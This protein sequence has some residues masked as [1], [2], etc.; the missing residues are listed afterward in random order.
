MI[1]DQKIT[2]LNSADVLR[3]KGYSFYIFTQPPQLPQYSD[4]MIDDYLPG[5]SSTFDWLKGK[6]LYKHQYEALCS[7]EEGKNVVLIAGTGSGK[8]E[9][10]VFYALKKAVSNK[11]VALATYPTLAL[12]NDQVNR[13]EKYAGKLGVSVIKI[14]K[15]T[16]DEVKAIKGGAG[17]RQAIASS[18][19]VLTNPAF[20]L[21]DIKRFVDKQSG[22]YLYTVLR[23]LD[24]LVIDELDFYTPRS[25]ALLLGMMKLLYTHLKV[26]RQVVVMTATLSNP[27]EMCSFLESL[28]GRECVIIRGNPFNVENRTLVVLGKNLRSIWEKIQDVKKTIL[29]TGNLDKDVLKALD[30]YSVFERNAYRVINYLRSLGVDVPSPALSIPELLEPYVNDHGVTIVFT[31]SINRA[32]E[33]Y[34]EL[35]ERNPGLMDK[36]AVHHHLVDRKK[37]EEI[38]MKARE[39]RIRIIISPRTLSQGIDIGTVIRIVHVGLPEELREFRQR[40]GRKGRRENIVFTESIVI[41]Q[42]VFDINLLSK[43]ESAFKKWLELPIEK[44]IVNSDNKYLYLFTGIA[45]LKST[46]MDKNLDEKEIFVL[47]KTRVLEPDGKVDYKRLDKV[48]FNLNF[49]EYSPPYGIPRSL[50]RED[51]EIPLEPI[52]RCDLVEKFQVGCFDLGSG[53]VVLKLDYGRGRNVS[54]VVE[55]ELSYR[56]LSMLDAFKDAVEQYRDIKLRWGESPE[57]IR[58][59]FRAKVISVV[60]TVVYPPKMGFGELIKIPNRVNWVVKSDKPR[61]VKLADNHHVVFDQRRISLPVSTHGEYRDFTSGIMIEAMENEDPILIRLGLAYILIVLRRVYSYSISALEYS[62]DAVG[63]KVFFE[64]HEPESSGLLEKIDWLDIRKSVEKY[65]PDELDLLLLSLIDDVAWTDMLTLGL[66]WD[67][68]K[69]GALRVIDY[70]LLMDK[71]QAFFKGKQIVIPKPSKALKLLSIEIVHLVDDSGSI[72]VNKLFISMFDGEEAKTLYAYYPAIRGVTPPDSLR[73]LEMELFDKVLYEGYTLIL[74]SIISMHSI[75]DK[76]DLRGLKHLL[77]DQKVNK[78]DITQLLEKLGLN[79]S[80]IDL[81]IRIGRERIENLTEWASISDIHK[82]LQKLKEKEREI[83]VEKIKQLLSMRT[84]ALYLLYLV[85]REIKLR[86][87]IRTHI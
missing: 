34:R 15:G 25:I 9:A 65:L 12:S 55:Y 22:A 11:F 27:E 32:E 54:R 66:D 59:V 80:S 71:I 29:A 46:W 67:V 58:D 35:L 5:I 84:K 39:G 83:D 14:D 79:P 7:L 37:R 41:P 75:A 86:E 63:G 19:I 36:V 24:L 1:Q 13:I 62:V 72:P 30:D 77:N 81:T 73:L 50:I 28:N 10:W 18:K 8:T 43:G 61:L 3:D 49:Y 17:L 20:L 60:D 4:V 85:L 21:S 44:T 38:E 68:P 87:E 52:G 40:E 6:K 69:R 42:G 70:L 48:W 57:L 78:V 51:K 2:P 16:R 53:G 76:C 56:T 47:R 33:L 82:H 26:P 45:K 74:P 23:D 64:L 31:R